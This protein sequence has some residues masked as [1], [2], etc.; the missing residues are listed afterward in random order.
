MATTSTTP[1]GAAATNRTTPPEAMSTSSKFMTVLAFATIFSTILIAIFVMNIVWAPDDKTEDTN[2]D[3]EDDRKPPGSTKGAT[4][5]N[6]IGVFVST[7]TLLT[8]MPG[9]HFANSIKI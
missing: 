8:L 5:R 7:I 3:E 4:I 2:T 9:Y 1:F 6:Y